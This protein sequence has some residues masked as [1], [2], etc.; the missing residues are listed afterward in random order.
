MTKSWSHCS[1]Q[2]ITTTGP[3]LNHCAPAAI[4]AV[5]DAVVLFQQWSSLLLILLSLIYG[6]DL[7][8]RIK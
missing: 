4:A 3:I 8:R 6:P 1:D 2:P 7:A 5:R